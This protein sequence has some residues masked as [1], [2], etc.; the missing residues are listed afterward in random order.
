MLQVL[1]R[2]FPLGNG[3]LEG[4][5]MRSMQK[6][7]GPQRQHHPQQQQQQGQ[8]QEVALLP[9]PKTQE[10]ADVVRQL[11]SSIDG[12]ESLRATVAALQVQLEGG[13]AADW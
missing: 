10:L 7:D 8:R 4:M 1:P 3:A 2:Y 9:I 5:L 13:A 12:S 11:G 6:Q